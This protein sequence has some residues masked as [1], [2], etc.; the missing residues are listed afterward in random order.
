MRSDVLAGANF[1]SVCAY[2]P[3]LAILA[4]SAIPKKIQ[5]TFGHAHVGNNSLGE[6]VTTLWPCMIKKADQI[7]VTEHRPPLTI[8][9]WGSHT[10]LIVV[11]GGSSQYLSHF[12]IRARIGGCHRWIRHQGGR[13]FGGLQWYYDQY[14]LQ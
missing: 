5:V 10:G 14:G 6:T 4:K 13:I 12:D 11:S 8:P 1:K 2:F 3:N 7:G 9:L